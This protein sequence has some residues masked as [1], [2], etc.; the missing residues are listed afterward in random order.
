[1]HTGWILATFLLI[2]NNRTAE[3]EPVAYHRTRPACAAG[4]FSA[5]PWIQLARTASGFRVRS[6]EPTSAAA[7][8]GLA[9]GDTISAVDGD[10]TA[11]WGTASLVGFS[12]RDLPCGTLLRVNGDGTVLV[13]H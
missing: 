2:P 12:H 1:M 3:P 10:T 8:A 6:I 9:V 4:A 7:R 5:A 13:V 11:D